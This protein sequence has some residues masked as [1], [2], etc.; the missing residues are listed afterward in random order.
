MPD[1]SDAPLSSAEL[2]RI[3][4]GNL[5]E[6]FWKLKST[7]GYRVTPCS[8]QQVSLAHLALLGWRSASPVSNGIG[9]GSRLLYEVQ[10]LQLCADGRVEAL[11]TLGRAPVDH[12]KYRQF[13]KQ[14]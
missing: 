9:K 3:I 13:R 11:G 8:W 2:D 4:D 1:V 5:T 7:P 14:A 10:A 6:E 12:V